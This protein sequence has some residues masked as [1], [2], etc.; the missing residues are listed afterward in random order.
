[1]PGELSRIT[2]KNIAKQW[3]RVNGAK[4][5][6]VRTTVLGQGTAELCPLN[7]SFARARPTPSAAS[8]QVTSEYKSARSALRGYLRAFWTVWSIATIHTYLP[9]RVKHRFWIPGESSF[10]YGLLDDGDNTWEC[11]A[12][13]DRMISE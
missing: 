2:E 11:T 10:I 4:K 7:R 8:I 5:E 1:L 6:V 3:S 9:E 13:N 12:T